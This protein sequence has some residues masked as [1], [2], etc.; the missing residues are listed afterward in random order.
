MTFRLGATGYN[1]PAFPDEA[2]THNGLWRVDFDINGGMND[3]AHFL[4]HKEP[5]GSPLTAKDNKEP[6]RKEEGRRWDTPEF[7]SLVVQDADTNRHGHK[8]AYEITPAQA[9]VY[10]HHGAADDWT[11]NDVYVTA[12]RENELGWTE[13]WAPPDNYLLPQVSA[14]PTV[15]R[16]LIVWIKASAHH[17]PIDED[18]SRRD[19]GQRGPTGVTLTHWSGFDVQPHNLFNT[20]PLG[21]PFRCGD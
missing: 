21:G 7:L 17:L 6:F 8:L 9:A 5:A 2:H 14:E 3:S 13:V 20:N 12:F 19:R 16:D 4:L 1:Y 15:G 18:K 10:R 11:R